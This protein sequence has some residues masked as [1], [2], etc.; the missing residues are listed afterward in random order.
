MFHHISG[1]LFLL[2]VVAGLYPDTCVP[3]NTLTY[4]TAALKLEF[5][6]RK[7]DRRVTQGLK[8]DVF[9]RCVC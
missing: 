7:S 9:D 8:D 4:V 1:L 2:S 3:L 5:A 6:V